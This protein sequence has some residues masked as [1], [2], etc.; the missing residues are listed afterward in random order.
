MTGPE[1]QL[2]D[3]L[4][5]HVDRGTVP[6]A[7]AVRG[8]LTSEPEVVA[9]GRRS[10]DGAAMD[11]TEIVRIQS[12]TKAITAVATLRLVERDRLA[13]DE[14]VATWLPELA[15]RQVLRT[16]TSALD[17]T[18]PA[19]GPI[20]ARQLLTNTSGYGM[21]LQDC[22][23]QR[24]MADNATEAG[25][26]PD[27]T[28]ASQWLARLAE[29]PLAFQP[30]H[31]WRYHHSFSVLGILLSR[32]TGMSLHDHVVAELFEPLG[33][34]DTGMWVS[35]T[36]VD[37]L[38]AAYRHA[39]S[40]L[41]ER[42]PAGGGPYA[43]AP[44]VDV[45]HGEL[46]SSAADYWRFLRA[47]DANDDGD[48]GRLL[49]WDHRAMMTT[50]QV[51]QRLKTPESFFPGFWDD[52]GWGFGVAVE[53]A[54]TRRG[55]YGWSGGLGTDFFVDPDGMAGLLLTQV[56]LDGTTMPLLQATQRI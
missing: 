44:D 28:A 51:P 42:E 55:R 27:G 46:V 37:R 38:P 33:M 54:G 8:E 15:D 40:G 41:V 30:G 14:D 43:G 49:S 22:P 26:A 19:N 34:P 5:S 23:L 10:V 48:G 3:V 6:G 47:L 13:L 29:L 52:A 1:G 36:A 32:V 4:Q 56:E 20:T 12:M 9:V 35:A 18:V 2:R 24:A 50:D 16:P 25:T 53:S 31:G 21:V 45:S 17:D 39:E 7:V 11:G